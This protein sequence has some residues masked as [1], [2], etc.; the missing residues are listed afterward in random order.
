MRL[1]LILR[2]P[3][4]LTSACTE[5]DVDGEKDAAYVIGRDA[6]ACWTIP[7]PERLLSKSHCRIN[8][9]GRKFLL[10]DLSTNGV[11][12][13]NVAVPPRLALELSH[14]DVLQLADAV[15]AVEINDH[16]LLT[17]GSSAGAAVPPSFDSR[18]FVAEAS[19]GAAESAGGTSPG[20]VFSDGPFGQDPLP[21]SIAKSPPNGLIEAVGGPG[22]R[23]IIGDWWKEAPDAAEDKPPEAV[24]NRAVRESDSSIRFLG[25]LNSFDAKGSDVVTSSQK[26]IADEIGLFARAVGSAAMV[27][28]ED[29]RRRFLDRLV[30]TLRSDAAGDE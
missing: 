19:G 12:V 9:A 5:F 20:I 10:T 24:H 28:Q 23:E 26:R 27:L 15:I 18:G 1:R 25:I 14:G 2:G 30:E 29:E 4:R 16:P 3:D 7:D 21:L 8:V 13:N 17:V 6:A 11:R 22:S